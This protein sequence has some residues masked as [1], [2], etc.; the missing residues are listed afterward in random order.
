M[1]PDALA[2]PVPCRWEE[3]GQRCPKPEWSLCYTPG[4][5][6]WLTQWGT[7]REAGNAAL[8]AMAAASLATSG[9]TTRRTHRWGEAVVEHTHMCHIGAYPGTTQGLR[10]AGRLGWVW[11]V[12]L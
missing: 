5:L 7:V 6:A 1:T 4:G 9:P 2:L 8:M 3:T 10:G 12:R 11:M